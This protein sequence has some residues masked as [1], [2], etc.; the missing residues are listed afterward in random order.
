MK[1]IKGHFNLHPSFV[2]S[3]ELLHSIAPGPSAVEA[4]SSIIFASP[5][6]ESKGVF[7]IFLPILFYLF[8]L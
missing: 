5:H 3:P 6:I 2:Y 7:R 4:A 1:S 8:I